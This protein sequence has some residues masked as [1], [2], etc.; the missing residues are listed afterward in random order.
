MINLIKHQDY[1]IIDSN[2]IKDLTTLFLNLN[3]EEMKTCLKDTLLDEDIYNSITIHEFIKNFLTTTI[4]IK[5][6]KKLMLISEKLILEDQTL[7][8][9]YNDLFLDIKKNILLS[10][11]KYCNH[12]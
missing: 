4:F 3:E 5:N 8:I 7:E 10:F 9:E 12:F 6:S 11:K 2:Q 1:F